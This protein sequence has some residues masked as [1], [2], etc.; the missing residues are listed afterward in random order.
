MTER[1]FDF[2]SRRKPTE[3]ADTPP[4]P[5]EDP[6]TEASPPGDEAPP[7]PAPAESSAPIDPPVSPAPA[8][9]TRARA[10]VPEAPKR[11]GRPSGKR[12]DGEYVQTTA[13]IR[14]KTHRAV[15][16][17]LIKDEG[18]PDFSELVD[19]LLDKWLKSRS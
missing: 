8:R 9:R 11:R 6:I 5:A 15:K 3:P 18:G 17:A 4:A 1:R 14:K 13:Y 7:S 12:S 10:S 2:L 16:V 19:D